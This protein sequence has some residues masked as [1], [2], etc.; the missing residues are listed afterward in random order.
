MYEP[1]AATVNVPYWPTTPAPGPPE[2]VVLGKAPPLP[3][4][5]L[6][7]SINVIV[8]AAVSSINKSSASPSFTTIV[9]SSFTSSVSFTSTTAWPITVM[10]KVW[11]DVAPCVSLT[12]NVNTS[13]TVWP[14]VKEAALFAI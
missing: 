13:V 12:V 7:C 14:S 5:P 3:S 2:F 1:S 10:V 11:V 8:V 6:V 4:V 9:S